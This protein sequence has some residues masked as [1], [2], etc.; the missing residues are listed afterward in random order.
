MNVREKSERSQKKLD[1]E[2]YEAA[3]WKHQAEKVLEQLE[4]E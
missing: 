3:R 4:R 2:E 1:L